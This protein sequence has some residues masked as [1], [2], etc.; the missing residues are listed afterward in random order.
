MQLLLKQEV[1]RQ[2]EERKTDQMIHPK[3]LVFEENKHKYRE[4]GER[5]RLL[6]HFQLPNIERTAIADK[7]NAIG[8]YLT[9]ILKQ[10]DAPAEQDYQR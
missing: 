9:T 6:N 7:T 1:N 8:W 5:Y 3:G 10:G 2:H 4:N